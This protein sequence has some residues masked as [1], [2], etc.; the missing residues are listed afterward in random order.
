MFQDT[1]L[2]T[3]NCMAFKAIGSAI[4]LK[5]HLN[6]Q[7]ARLVPCYLYLKGSEC[8]KPSL[9]LRWEG[10]MGAKEIGNINEAFQTC[11]QQPSTECL[12]VPSPDT[13][14]HGLPCWPYALS[15]P[16]PTCTAHGVQTH[17]VVTGMWVLLW[18]GCWDSPACG[19]T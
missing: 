6:G 2:L 19:N 3:V 4:D 8:M 7:Q 5:G 17:W 15:L 11:V 18:Q 14:L 9:L 12:L 16:L 10:K 13:V 1:C